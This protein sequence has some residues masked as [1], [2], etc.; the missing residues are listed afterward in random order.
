MKKN[1]S[2]NI[3]KRLFNIDE[4]AYECLNSYLYRLR[5]YFSTEEGRE[6]ILAD[7]EMRIAEL[8]EQ[9]VEVKGQGIVILEFVQ[10]IIKE[11]GEPG[12]LSDSDDV[13]PNETTQQRTTGKLFRD[14]VNRKVGG[15]AAGLSAFFG[16]DPVW[17]R[18]IFVFSTLLYGSGPV[19]YIVL[20]IILPEAQT[21]S[22]K[23]EMQRQNVNIGTLRN[24]LASAGKG[25]QKTGSSFLGTL[26]SFLRNVFEIA[27][28]LIR[29]FFQLFGRLTGLLMLGLVL[30]SYVGIGLALLIREHVGMGGYQFDSVT[31]YQVF[32]WM[33]PGTSDRWLFYIAFLMV[34]IAISGLLIYG[35]LRLLLKWP[36][37]RWPVAIAF[38]LLL[39]AGFLTAGAAI[40]RYSRSTDISD[41]VSQYN[42]LVMPAGK[43]HIQSGPWDFEKFLNPLSGNIGKNRDSQVLGEINLS[44]RP[45]PGDSLILTLI[46]SASSTN[47][48]RSAGFASKIQYSWDIGDTL[49]L[50]NPYYLMPYDDGMHYQELNV[51]VGI[52]VN[53]EIFLDPA[54]SWK[55]RY[56]D[57]KDSNSEGGDYRMTT[58]GLVRKIEEVESA[59]STKLV[60]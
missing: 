10:E 13:R 23:L 50:I 35:G 26:G 30:L 41:S 40:Y 29:W 48:S 2:V 53:K 59:D 12:Q 24:E 39:F 3:G 55:I 52:P 16:I 25:I 17:L 45:A 27:A 18:L 1:F 28:R 33:V 58:S 9:K 43:L 42:S 8:L 31:Q 5:G 60:K 54:I 32:Q 51:I 46:R 22:E 21:T 34:L 20:W 36:P 15:V 47:R 11:M 49:L 44:L 14:P 4:D 57:F 38:L 19:I 56:S 7:I 37:L 6:E